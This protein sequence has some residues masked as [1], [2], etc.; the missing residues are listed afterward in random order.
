[1][2]FISQPLISK[3]FLNDRVVLILQFPNKGAFQLQLLQ[4]SRRS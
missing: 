1:M 3:S 4:V 2:R